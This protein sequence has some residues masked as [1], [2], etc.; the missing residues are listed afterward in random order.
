MG[1]YNDLGTGTNSALLSLYVC[2]LQSLQIFCCSCN[3]LHCV[4]S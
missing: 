3:C 1:N 2:S 4:V